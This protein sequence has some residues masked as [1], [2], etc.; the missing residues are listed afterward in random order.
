MD[1]T[2]WTLQLIRLVVLCAVLI[3]GAYTE[4]SKGKIF[5]WLTVPGIL[6]GLSLGYLLS[7]FP[8]PAQ[9]ALNLESSLFGLL[10]GGGFFFIMYC[11]GAMGAGDVKMMGAVGALGG[12][13]FTV[14]AMFFSA[15]A[16]GFMAFVILLIRGKTLEGMRDGVRLLFTLRHKK[17]SGETE[18]AGKEQKTQPDT[19]PYGLAISIGTF[20]AILFL[21]GLER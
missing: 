20:A 7:S 16:G 3:I 4:I 8:Q 15:V 19:V 13:H 18:D 5:N 9:T 21:K 11:V 2:Y 10:I 1:S 6:I 12:W 17:G 14:W